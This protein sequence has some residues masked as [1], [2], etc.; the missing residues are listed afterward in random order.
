MIAQIKGLIKKSIEGSKSGNCDYCQTEVI[1][2]PNLFGTA[3]EI[4]DM[5]AS[6]WFLGELSSL[7]FSNTV[8]K[9]NRYKQSFARYN[10][11]NVLCKAASA[12]ECQ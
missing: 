1:T 6:K 8:D 5:F 3:M 2:F 12:N 9:V 11:P 7:G 10:D 4:D